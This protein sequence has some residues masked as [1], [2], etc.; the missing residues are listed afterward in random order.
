MQGGGQPRLHHA[1]RALNE[2]RYQD[3]EQLLAGQTDPRAMSQSIQEQLRQ[4][5]GLPVSDIRS[6]TEVVS[7]S[8]SRQRFCLRRR[9]SPPAG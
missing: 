9:P 3:V 1:L 8:V 2:G 7:L 6:M 4:A 5:T